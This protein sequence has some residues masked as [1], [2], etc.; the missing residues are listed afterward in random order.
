VIPTPRVAASS[1]ETFSPNFRLIPAL[2]L[3]CSAKAPFA[4][5]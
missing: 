2:A 4:L 5:S 1:N 3:M